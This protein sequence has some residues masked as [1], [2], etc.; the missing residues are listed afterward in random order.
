MVFLSGLVFDVEICP[1]LQRIMNEILA[2]I[3]DMILHDKILSEM[4]SQ[5]TIY[6]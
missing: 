4:S 6:Q 2:F 5:I 3:V 1:I